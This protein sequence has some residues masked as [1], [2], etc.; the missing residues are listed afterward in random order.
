M[1]RKIM[2]AIILAGMLAAFSGAEFSAAQADTAEIYTASV[3]VSDAKAKAGLTF[4]KKVGTPFTMYTSYGSEHKDASYTQWIN[5]AIKALENNKNYKK[6]KKY[7]DSAI[8]PDENGELNELSKENGEFIIDKKFVPKVTGAVR[9]DLDGDS[10]VEAYVS[11]RVSD[12][13]TDCCFLVY[14]DH[15]GKGRIVVNNPDVVLDSVLDYGSFSHV[16]VETG[17]KIKI[18]TDKAKVLYTVNSTWLQHDDKSNFIAS[19]NLKT[20]KNIVFF[21]D[22]T[23]KRYVDNSRFP[24]Y[25]VSRKTHDMLLKEFNAICEE[26]AVFN[27]AG[28]GSVLFADKTNKYICSENIDQKIYKDAEKNGYYYLPISSDYAST[29]E[30]LY[31]RIRKKLSVNFISDKEM[32]KYLFE[33]VKM[34]LW[35]EDSG[36]SSRIKKELPRFREGKNGLEVFQEYGPGYGYRFCD[37]TFFVLKYNGKTADIIVMSKDTGGDCV[38]RQVRMKKS[39]KYGWQLDAWEDF[40]SI[41]R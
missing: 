2:T 23:K 7:I 24:T 25:K 5:A 12:N 36:K 26:Y 19:F 8:Y 22:G 1:N 9:G 14:V 16:A 6:A 15:D 38:F 41:F 17:G 35:V 33:P 39:S 37:E 34:E 29:K 30:E 31:N 18:C 4:G 28:D 21:W 40:D 13:V 20:E 3:S 27:F 11:L 10:K 32:D